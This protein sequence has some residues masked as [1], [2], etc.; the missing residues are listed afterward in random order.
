MA[1]A[2]PQPEAQRLAE[3]VAAHLHEQAKASRHLGI[4]TTGIGPG[5]AT[6]TMT[7]QPHLLNGVGTCHGGILATLADTAFALACN[8]Y[9][10]PA[11][12]SHFSI[13]LLKPAQL[14]DVLTAH[15]TERSRGKRLGVYDVEVHNQH[16][17]LIALFRG[18]SYAL[19]G[20]TVLP[21]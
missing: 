12:A 1:E 14:H 5:H 3:Q 2:A 21:A 13:D 11:V 15:A 7:V 18:H 10:E 4:L 17:Q 9:N 16:G 8:S 6:T 20:H 19:Q